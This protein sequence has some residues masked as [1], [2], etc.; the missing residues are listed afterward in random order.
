[1]PVSFFTDNERVLPD[2][3][4]PK[5]CFFLHYYRKA[6]LDKNIIR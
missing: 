5:R 6:K 2:R 4:I 1:M 3:N